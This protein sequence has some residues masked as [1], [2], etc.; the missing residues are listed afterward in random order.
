MNVS[1]DPAHPSD[2]MHSDCPGRE[3]FKL[4]TG[5]W[6]LLILWS[7][8]SGPLRFHRIRDTVEGISERVLSSTLK[9]LCRHGLVARHVE[10]TIPPKVSY[11]LSPCGEG[12]LEVMNNLTAWIA[13]ELEGIEQAKQSFDQEL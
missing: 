13:R 12:L 1:T 11:E 3:V 8:K 5:R 2:P 6:T 7:M 9:E 10:A 4:I